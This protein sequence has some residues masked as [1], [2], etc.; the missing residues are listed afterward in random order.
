MLMEEVE[1]TAATSIRVLEERAGESCPPVRAV[2]VIILEADLNLRITSLDSVEPEPQPL[3]RRRKP[4]SR[5]SMVEQEAVTLLV[6]GPPP[7]GPAVIPIGEVLEA[8]Q[9]AE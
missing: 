4:A 3:P 6:Q 7:E 9:E 5:R 8:A 2:T 1:A